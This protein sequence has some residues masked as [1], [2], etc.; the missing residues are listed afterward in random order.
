M[1]R[2]GAFEVASRLGTTTKY[3]CSC[4][5]G[6]QGAECADICDTAGCDFNSY[7]NGDKTFYGPGPGFTVDSTK[8]MTARFCAPSAGLST[9][10]Q[11]TTLA[12]NQHRKH[13]GPMLPIA[14]IATPPP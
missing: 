1:G 6:Y 10:P 11:S 3:V 13:H 4:Y 2:K 5:A 9:R 8:P 12:S 14:T 7:R